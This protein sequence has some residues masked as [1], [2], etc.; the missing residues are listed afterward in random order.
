MQ[1]VEICGLMVFCFN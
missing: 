1:F